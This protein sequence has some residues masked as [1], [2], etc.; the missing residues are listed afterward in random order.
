M[1]VHALHPVIRFP[2]NALWQCTVGLIGTASLQFRVS[3]SVSMH[4]TPW[5]LETQQNRQLLY[6]PSCLSASQQ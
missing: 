5:E 2:R 6:G 4:L 3:N 1:L